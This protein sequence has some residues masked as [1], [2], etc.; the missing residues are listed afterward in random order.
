MRQPGRESWAF[1]CDP[2][3]IYKVSLDKHNVKYYLIDMAQKK[4]DLLKQA[5]SLLGKK[6]GRARA[7]KYDK[8]TL[9][10]WAKRGGRPRK[11]WSELSPAGKFQRKYRQARK[12]AEKNSR[13]G[14]E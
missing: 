8:K 13:K 3:R 10:K 14:A 5:A 4:D 11:K 1:G 9:T 2:S 12:A 7:A 6:G